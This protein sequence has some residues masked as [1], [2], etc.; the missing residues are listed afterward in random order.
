MKL[1]AFYV[2]RM[3]SFS[4]ALD[5]AL[6]DEEIERGFQVAVGQRHGER[7][8]YIALSLAREMRLAHKDL[9]QITVAGLLHDIGAIAN[10]RKCHGDPKILLEHCL[11]GAEMIR[12]FPEGEILSTV[13][14][15]HH[16]CPDPNFGILKVDPALVPLLARII[17]LADKLDIHL[18]RH[19]LSHAQ[20]DELLSWI[21]QFNGTLFFP[22]V[23][24]ALKRLAHREAFWLNLE[25]PDLPEVVLSMLYE[26]WEFEATVELEQGFTDILAEIFAGLV[27]QKSNFTARHSH[28]V[29]ENAERLAWGLGW[30]SEKRHE[31][32]VA[33]LLHDLGKLGMPNEILDKPGKLAQNEIEVIRT[34]TYYTHRLLTEAGFPKRVVGWAAYHHERLDGQG[35]PFGLSGE[36][37]DTG[38]RLMAIAD[39][40]AALTEERPYRKALSAEESINIIKKSGGSALDPVLIALAQRVLL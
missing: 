7:V 12:D 4:R 38:A 22:E 16:E 26:R 1:D 27:D 30:G 28:S 8:A 3:W 32:F 23:V 10:F 25:Q 14:R 19:L 37:L 36:E 2:R 34:H 17:S 9:L 6:V 33:G 13:I 39:I 24:E 20:R 21:T 29:A 31:I 35:Y 11:A 5:L 15:Y 18:P 40:F